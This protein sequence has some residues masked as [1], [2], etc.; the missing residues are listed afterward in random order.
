MGGIHCL[1][2]DVWSIILA[3]ASL[4][5]V[6]ALRLTNKKVEKNIRE[7][8]FANFY[9]T[10]DNIP[11]ESDIHKYVQRIYLLSQNNFPL[12]IYGLRITHLIIGPY[13]VGNVKIPAS[14]KHFE[15]FQ[16]WREI[17]VPHTV[18]TFYGS[19]EWKPKIGDHV[20]AQYYNYR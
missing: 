5:D 15:A 17:E 6:K 3:Q 1:G 4:K 18:T 7:Y 10:V 9:V 8:V 16:F 2:K 12:E 20:T 14:V 19:I 13:C 11:K